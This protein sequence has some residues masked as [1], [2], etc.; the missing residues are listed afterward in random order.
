MPQVRWYYV[1]VKDEERVWPE[2]GET[3][4]AVRQACMGIPIADQCGCR[5][6]APYA[7]DFF[8]KFASS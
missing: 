8:K 1:V 6:I 7:S 3:K 4:L 5:D 2:R